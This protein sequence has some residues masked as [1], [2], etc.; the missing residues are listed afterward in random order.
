[1]NPE[2]PQSIIASLNQLLE[3]RFV[4][5]SD[6]KFDRFECLDRTGQLA[7][8]DD[9]YECLSH[10]HTGLEER[11]MRR[12]LF[13]PTQTSHRVMFGKLFQREGYDSVF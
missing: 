12:N 8:F 6:S 10:A 11:C 9:A 13:G 3:G 1:M 5:S 2:Q 7:S 4:L